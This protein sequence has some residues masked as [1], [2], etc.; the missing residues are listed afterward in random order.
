ME[1]EDDLESDNGLWS[2]F[3]DF[4]DVDFVFDGFEYDGEFLWVKEK[5]GFYFWV[6]FFICK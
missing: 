3:E 1:E 2:K 5:S 6:E 4:D